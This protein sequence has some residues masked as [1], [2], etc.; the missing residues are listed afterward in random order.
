MWPKWNSWLTLD[1]R[2]VIFL[3]VRSVHT[4]IKRRFDMQKG[5]TSYLL[6][7]YTQKSNVDSICRRVKRPTCSCL[8]TKTLDVNLF[9]LEW[10]VKGENG[11]GLVEMGGVGREWVGFG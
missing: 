5:K 3:P 11:W 2:R 8:C 9:G 1:Y 7:P 6:D 4:E 10:V